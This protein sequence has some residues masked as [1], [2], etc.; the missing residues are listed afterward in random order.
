[1][2]V[3]LAGAGLAYPRLNTQ[4]RHLIGWRDITA[5]LGPVRWPVQVVSVIHSREKLQKILAHTIPEGT[6]RAPAVDYRRREAI[7]IAL[8]P[9]SSTGYDL[10][11]TRITE[12]SR[13]FVVL[14]ERTPRLG[15]HV[16]PMLTFPYRLITIPRTDKK[17]RF[18]IIGRL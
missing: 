3:A 1:V 17:V 5:E 7:L 15:Q 11:V 6:P 8:G 18:H 12:S 9:R 16:T 4:K 2:V 10:R 14:R 13:I